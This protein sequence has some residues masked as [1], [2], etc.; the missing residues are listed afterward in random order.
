MTEYIMRETGYPGAIKQEI[1]GE[2]VRCEDCVH[3]KQSEAD[4]NRKMCWRKDVD[5][6][7]I[8]Y[9]FYPTDFCSYGERRK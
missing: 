5:G 2:L 6:F 7:P 1:V 4:P 8:C 3:Y 9:D